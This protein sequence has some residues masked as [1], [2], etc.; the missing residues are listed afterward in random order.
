MLQY[1]KTIVLPQQV[2]L[3]TRILHVE[4]DKFRKSLY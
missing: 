4:K 2:D 1:S 3:S